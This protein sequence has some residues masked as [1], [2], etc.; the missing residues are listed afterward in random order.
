MATSSQIA[1]NPQGDTVVVAADPTAPLGVQVLSTGVFSQSERNIFRVVNAGTVTVHLGVGSTAA[2]AQSAAVAA[3]AG[4]PAAGLPLV[5]GAV[6][7]LRF[8]ANDYVSGYAASAATVYITPG[9]G[10]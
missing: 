3:T 10:L 5:P 2:A 6:E 9:I 4:S 1:F 8:G 7:V